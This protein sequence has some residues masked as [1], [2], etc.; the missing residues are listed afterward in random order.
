MGSGIASRPGTYSRPS[1]ESMS[2]YDLY[3]ELGRDPF[4]SIVTEAGMFYMFSVS[5][6]ILL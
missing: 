3:L 6:T 2:Y 4:L 5:S 1:S